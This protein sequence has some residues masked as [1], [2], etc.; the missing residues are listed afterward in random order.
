MNSACASAARIL[1]PPES[2]DKGPDISS[3]EKPRPARMRRA[4]ASEAYASRRS[5]SSASAPSLA[6]ASRHFASSQAFSVA[7]SA[8]SMASMSAD[9]SLSRA[10]ILESHDTSASSAERS[11]ASSSCATHA[12]SCTLALMRPDA[13]SLTSVDL[14]L[15]F[16]PRSA[17]FRPLAILNDAS[18]KRRTPRTDTSMPLTS[19]TASVAFASSSSSSFPPPPRTWTLTASRALAQ[20]SGALRGPSRDAPDGPPS[21][22]GSS[23]GRRPSFS[24]FASILRSLPVSLA[25]SFRLIII[26]RS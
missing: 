11:P 15:P 25:P 1:Q 21:S 4:L 20:D 2:F 9:S 24:A 5:S 23:E 18:S 19:T 17:T 6:D 12:T 10:S 13:M 7:F 22:G 26:A 14:P 8:A 3:S 16:A